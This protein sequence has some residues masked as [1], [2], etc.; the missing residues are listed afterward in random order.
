MPDDGCICKVVAGASLGV[1]ILII[2]LVA[3]SLQKLNSDEVGISYNQISKVMGE[4]PHYEGM[5]MGY[6][7]F[8]Y[9]EFSSVFKT[10]SH[11]GM[12]CINKDGVEISLDI[13]YQYRIRGQNLFKIVTEFR[14]HETF[15][16]VLTFIGQA[17][18]YDSC[19]KFNTSQFQSEWGVF[20]EFLRSQLVRDYDHVFVDVTDLQVNDIQRPARYESAIRQKETA[21]EDILVAE[22][23]RP[24]RLTEAETL[25]KEAETE[26]QI[27]IDRA[28]SDSKVT[29]NQAY[30]DASAI[31]TEYQTEAETYRKLKDA[32]SGLGLDATG[33]LAYM[34]VRTLEEAKSHVQVSLDA[35]AKTMFFP[36]G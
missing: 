11:W 7:G 12:L 34:S 18:I 15:S 19:K 1:V 24:R 21:R 14:D 35:P 3:S 8:S 10:I 20:Q 25:Q 27:T 5:H 2:A 13:G 30:A 36:S 28:A 23:E 29:L 9:I 32:D 17:A 26:A 22:S 16:Q 31:M 6:P 33:F 4:G